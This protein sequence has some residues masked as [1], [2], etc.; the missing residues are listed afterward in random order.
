[1]KTTD[2]LLIGLL[3][4]AGVSYGL[5]SWLRSKRRIDLAGRVV[6]ITGGTTGL[7]LLLAKQ[8]AERGAVLVLAARDTRD[9]E[10]AEAEVRSHGARDVLTVPTDVADADQAQAL[11]ARTVERF[12]RIDVLLNNAGIMIVGPV[13]A[14]TL[15]DYRNLLGTNFWGAVHTTLAA[16]PHMRA[17]RSGRI[18]NIISIGGRFAAPHMAP[19]IASKYA[20]TGFTKALRA[21]LTRDNILITGIYPPTI[22]TGGHAHAWFKGDRQA[23]YT[24]FALGDTVPGLA[25]SADATARKAWTAIC[26]GDPELLVGLPTRIAVVFDNL[27]PEWSA[28]LTALIE[29]SMPGPVNLDGPA[30]QGKDLGGAI[31][32]LL[33]RL[34]PA[35]TRP[36]G[37]GG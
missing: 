19:Y 5:K 34:I 18:A 31:P 28:E 14:M 25:L 1:M 23:E 17:A 4:G 30:V 29:R 33:S 20:L 7:G 22:R 26:D 16:L 35:A 11:I 15:D 24:W 21:E 9:L 13:A 36:N 27:F 3:A 32:G 10:A 6:V 8:A 2:K 12:G 37:V